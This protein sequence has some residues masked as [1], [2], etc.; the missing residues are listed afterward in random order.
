MLET[1]GFAKIRVIALTDEFRRVTVDLLE[2]EARY[3]DNL[4]PAVGEELFYGR[5]VQL[6]ESL[7]A[8]DAGLL[9]RAL[10]LAERPRGC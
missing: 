4:R 1:A 5:Q 9:R 2:L 6:E 10:F 3:E 7:E 8:I